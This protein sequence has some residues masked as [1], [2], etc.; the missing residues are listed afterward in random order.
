[1]IPMDQLDAARVRWERKHRELGLPVPGEDEVPEPRGLATNVEE[2]STRI[3]VLP[4]DPFATNLSFDEDFWNWWRQDRPSPFGR[5]V[6][7][8]GHRPTFD[9]AAKFRSR[10]ES[11]STYIALHRHGGVEVGTADAYVGRDAVRC[12]RLG[13]AVALL[14]LAL[15]ELAG[16]F[17]RSQTEGPWEVLVAFHGTFGAHLEDLGQGWA[18]PSSHAWDAPRC[19]EPSVV[20]RREFSDVPTERDAIRELALDFGSRIDDAWGFE[21][22]RVLDRCGEQEGRFVPR[23]LDL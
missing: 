23:S 14:W 15:E 18:E 17:E 3:V 7:W 5:P 21:A 10:G 16:S 9:A 8:H 13:R 20:L 11:W 6:L 22:S 4:H 12:F 2:L 1:M 19:S